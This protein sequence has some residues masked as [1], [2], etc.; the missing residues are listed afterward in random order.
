MSGCN[1]LYSGRN[2]SVV[3]SAGIQGPYAPPQ[4]QNM[5]SQMPEW[6]SQTQYPPT[7][8]QYM[9]SKASKGGSQTAS[10]KQNTDLSSQYEQARSQQSRP[11][12][13]QSEET[14]LQQ[15][16]SQSSQSQKSRP[17]PSEPEQSRREQYRREETIMSSQ[18]R[19]ERE[20]QAASSLQQSSI[21][22]YIAKTGQ[23]TTQPITEKP[24]TRLPTAAA[25]IG[26]PRRTFYEGLEMTTKM[27]KTETPQRAATSRQYSSSSTR[28]NNSNL[29]EPST[30]P[31]TQKPNDSR[32]PTH[33]D[34]LGNPNRTF[35]EGLEAKT[36]MAKPQ[37][38]Q[39][40]ETSRQ[41]S[42]STTTRT[43]SSKLGEQ[44]T[45]PVTQKQ[46][47]IRMPTNMDLLGNPNRTVYE[48]MLPKTE[49]KGVERAQKAEEE[50]KR[51][52]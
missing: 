38:P 11:R 25:P 7:Q 15:S 12:L 26:D 2:A 6:A 44:S 14:C 33:M 8:V 28:A 31:A 1:P 47:D 22:P 3:G 35:V 46:N 42:S 43:D 19:S 32:M 17:Q 49:M 51:Q 29:G 45:Y 23:P 50:R 40:G 34:L 4:G 27:A 37:K 41:D 5:P 30:Y 18:G 48:G 20:S 16:R 39:R 36:K 52:K 13:T 9:L 10:T 24:N 21:K